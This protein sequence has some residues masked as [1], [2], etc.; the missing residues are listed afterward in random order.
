MA[1]AAIIA[2]AVLAGVLA[3]ILCQFPLQLVLRK[4]ASFSSKSIC[5]AVF[6]S[7][8][9]QC[10]TCLTC[11]KLSNKDL[12]F[13]AVGALMHTCTRMSYPLFHPLSLLAK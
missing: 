9:Y 7:E 11:S 10:H 1:S 4:A 12:S 8:R 3:W 6:L 13:A 5:S 2:A